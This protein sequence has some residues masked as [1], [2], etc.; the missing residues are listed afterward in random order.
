MD[1]GAIKDAAMLVLMFVV[2]GVPALALAARLAIRPVLDAILQLR[3]SSTANPAVPDPRIA[4][5]ETEV[6]RL[7][8]QVQRLSES[9]EFNRQLIRGTSPEAIPGDAIRTIQP[10]DRS[11]Q[12]GHS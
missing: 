4:A 9:D 10:P 7:G 6:S 1:F 5:L 2:F 3:A 12:R 8:V 11:Q